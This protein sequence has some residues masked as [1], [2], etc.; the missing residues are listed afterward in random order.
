MKWLYALLS[1]LGWKTDQVHIVVEKKESATEPFDLGTTFSFT[2]ESDGHALRVQGGRL[3]VNGKEW[4]PDGEVPKRTSRGGL[5]IH[6]LGGGVSH[7]HVDGW[8]IKLTPESLTVNGCPF[9]PL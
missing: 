4:V 1:K 7:V 9:V 2:G 5:K 6:A 3:F 8:D